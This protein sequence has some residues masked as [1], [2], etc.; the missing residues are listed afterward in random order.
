MTTIAL[1]VPPFLTR[2]LG[3]TKAFILEGECLISKTKKIAFGRIGAQH[4]LV[5]HDPKTGYSF[6]ASFNHMYS[7]ECISKIFSKLEKLGVEVKN[8]EIQLLGGWAT[9][10][11]SDACSMRILATLKKNKVS[12]V[13]KHYF[14]RKEMPIGSLSFKCPEPQQRRYYYFGGYFHS[15]SGTFHFNRHIDWKIE[16]RQLKHQRMLTKE[17]LLQVYPETDFSDYTRKE[18]TLEVMNI[19]PKDSLPFTIWVDR[20]KKPTSNTD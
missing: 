19:V 7:V 14:Q 11:T 10:D 9:N 18:K 16:K 12:K 5:G 8:L 13:C 6:A 1:P 2:C 15:Q 4:L 3:P 20:T 17:I